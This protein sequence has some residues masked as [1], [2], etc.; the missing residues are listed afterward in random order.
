M[1][2]SRRA[3]L[4]SGGAVVAAAGLAA[5]SFRPKGFTEIG[6]AALLRAYGR[7]LPH[8]VIEPFLADAESFLR[9]ETQLETANTLYF[10]DGAYGLP[11]GF[12]SEDWIEAFMVHR[13]AMSTTV[14]AAAETGDPIEYTGFFDPHGAP[15][16]NQ[17]SYF[18]APV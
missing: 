8:D 13:F 3:V 15:C 11:E 9:R 14:I 2:I 4:L 7:E 10:M 1:G 6:R 16:S 12:D 5:F 17:L 18:N